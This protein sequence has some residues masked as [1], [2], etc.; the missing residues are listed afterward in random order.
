MTFELRRTM[1]TWIAAGCMTFAA[2]ATGCGNAEP[3]AE[4]VAHAEGA[5]PNAPTSPTAQQTRCAMEYARIYEMMGKGFFDP[6]ADLDSKTP[7]NKAQSE[8][9]ASKQDL[10]RAAIAVSKIENCDFGTDFT[11][12]MDIVLPHLG[13]TR[14]CCKLLQYDAHRVLFGPR[15]QAAASERLAAILRIA[16][17]AGTEPIILSKLVAISCLHLA[18]ESIVQWNKPIT[19]AELRAMLLGELRASRDSKIFERK[20]TVQHE[21]RMSLISINK[22]DGWVGIDQTIQIP[23][24]ERPAVISELNR[25]APLIDQAID[26]PDAEERVKRILDSMR[27]PK[28]RLFVAGTDVYAKQMSKAERALDSAIDALQ[29]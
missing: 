4:P 23:E 12:G 22:G 11:Q 3:A 13:T 18:S 7:P 9:L 14:H 19:D 8:F 5:P 1:R 27:L 2:L 10:V 29:K 15:G 16:R 28:A 26:A 17:H 20:P 6:L 25:V 24:S 21:L